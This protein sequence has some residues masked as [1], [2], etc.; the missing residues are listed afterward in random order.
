MVIRYV[1]GV[2]AVPVPVEARDALVIDSPVTRPLVP[3][4]VPPKVKVAPYALVWL[5]AVMVSGA[6]LMVSGMSPETELYAGLVGVKVQWSL[7]VPP[8]PGPTLVWV[9]PLR[10]PATTTPPMPVQTTL[11]EWEAPS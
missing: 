10:V 8:A 2:A 11:A 3:N 4:S 6:G 7:Y 9:V 5:L 1:P